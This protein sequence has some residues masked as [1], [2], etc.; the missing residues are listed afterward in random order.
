[1]ASL[2]DDVLG[3]AKSVLSFKMMEETFI[4]SR[5]NEVKQGMNLT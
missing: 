3:Q 1:M 4:S 5:T 2:R